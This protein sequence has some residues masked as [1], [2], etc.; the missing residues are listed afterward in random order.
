M[1]PVHTLMCLQA[2]A[3]NGLLA[4]GW[5]YSRRSNKVIFHEHYKSVLALC[6]GVGDGVV[7]GVNMYMRGIAA[8]HTPLTT[9]TMMKDETAIQCSR[10]FKFVNSANIEAR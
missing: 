5:G 3:S 9:T 1:L 6:L 10:Q 7:E 2:R 8:P 4:L